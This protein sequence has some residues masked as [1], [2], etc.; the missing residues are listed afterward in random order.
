M[1]ETATQSGI[2]VIGT[3][4]GVGKTIVCSGLV[5]L[6][7]G[8]RKV[9]YWKPIQTGTIVG[10]DTKAARA[11]TDLGPENFM[12]PVY[13]FPEPLSPHMA[14]KKWGKTVDLDVITKFYHDNRKDRFVIIEGAGGVLVP[15]NEKH[16]QVDLFKA[17]KLP[18]LIVTEDRV[19]AINQT[20]LTLDFLRD[21]KLEVLGVV[22]TRAR[23]TLGN[24]EAIALFGKVEVLAE[25]DPTE[26]ARTVVG[27]VGA[28]SRLREMFNMSKLPG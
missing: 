9:C 20:L 10:D 21:E 25:F 28:N 14:A 7:H 15:L 17:L 1:G 4:T 27:Q 18:I 26:D 3:D 13:R 23:R 22:M 5:K 19:G 12:D 8:Q 2:F 11:L 6:L 16:L 24:A